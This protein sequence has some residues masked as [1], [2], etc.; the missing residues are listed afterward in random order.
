MQCPIFKNGRIKVELIQYDNDLPD[1]ADDFGIMINDTVELPIDAWD[2][3]EMEGLINNKLRAGWTDKSQLYQ[4]LNEYLDRVTS[5]T[6]RLRKHPTDA[7]GCMAEYYPTMDCVYTRSEFFE[8][9]LRLDSHVD[10]NDL[11]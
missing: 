6:V 4:Y 10:I 8:V 9:L 1:N 2:R 7:R 5:G 11:V 3:D